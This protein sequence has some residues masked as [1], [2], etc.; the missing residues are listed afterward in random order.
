MHMHTYIFLVVFYNFFQMV[1]VA[2][3]IYN[4][5]P[6]LILSS[7]VSSDFSKFSNNDFAESYTIIELSY[8][9]IIVIKCMFYL[10]SSNSK[11]K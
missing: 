8:T 10:H 3:N 11:C 4:N 1:E 9:K 7:L 2:G 6:L 5:I